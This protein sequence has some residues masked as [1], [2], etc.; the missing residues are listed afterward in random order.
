MKAFPMIQGANTPGGDIYMFYRMAL[1]KLD[2]VLPHGK[3]QRKATKG[4]EKLAS[5]IGKHQTLGNHQIAFHV[6]K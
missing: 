5:Q 3:W 6:L 4:S 2:I 1:G